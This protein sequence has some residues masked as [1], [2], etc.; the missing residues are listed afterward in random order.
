MPLFQAEMRMDL[1]R[2]RIELERSKRALKKKLEEVERQITE[3]NRDILEDMATAGLRNIP[4]KDG[5]TL[6][7]RR[8]LRCSRNRSI[9][10]DEALKLL[11]KTELAD[12]VERTCSTSKLKEWLSEQETEQGIHPEGPAMHLPESVRPLFSIYEDN[13]IVVTGL[14]PLD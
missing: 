4:M 10:L 13:K 3:T 9:P 2:E 14:K 12:L 7:H 11:Q 6:S 5:P 8:Y 1:V